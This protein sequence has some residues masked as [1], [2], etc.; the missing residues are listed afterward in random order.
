MNDLRSGPRG[1]SG[2]PPKRGTRG[3]GHDD[4]TPF[5]APDWMVTL[6]PYVCAKPFHPT[7][8][9]TQDTPPQCQLCNQSMV[10]W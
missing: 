5:E 8:F 4:G 1:L 9:S 6:V 7:G 3:V 2:P 10:R